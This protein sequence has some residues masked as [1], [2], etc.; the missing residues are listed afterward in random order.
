MDIEFVATI[1]VVTP[2][3]TRSRRLYVDALSLPL[4]GTEGDYAHSEVIAGCKSFGIWPLDQAAQACFGTTRWPVDRPVPQISLEFDVRSADAVNEAA[5]ELQEAGHDL[6]HGA[7]TEPWG[8]TVARL[9]SQG[10][11]ITDL[12][13]SQRGTPSR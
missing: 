5:R 7:R 2:D 12:R 13:P 6:L 3:P 1:A 9:Q 11:G 10:P 4:E 8:Q